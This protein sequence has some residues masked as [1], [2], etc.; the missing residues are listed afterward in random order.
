MHHVAATGVVVELAQQGSEFPYRDVAH[1]HHPGHHL[2]THAGVAVIHHRDGRSLGILGAHHLEH[3]VVHGHHGKAIDVEHAQEELVVLIL[4][5]Q[6]VTA[7]VDLAAHRGLDDD[8]L[9]QVLADRV[10][11]LFDVGI[12]ETG[13]I[14]GGPG[15]ASHHQGCRHSG[16]TPALPFIYHSWCYSNS[17]F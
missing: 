4:I 14:L 11:E 8:G 12:L 2:V 15:R 3:A 7:D 5:E 1:R 6:I 9:V 16:Q 10:D 13:G 17:L